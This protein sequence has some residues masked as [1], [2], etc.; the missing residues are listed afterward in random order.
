M[1]ERNNEQ[2]EKKQQKHTFYAVVSLTKQYYIEE[3]FHNT[4][5]ADGVPKNHIVWLTVSLSYRQ[6]HSPERL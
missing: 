6:H 5:I 2:H 3:H 1:N 4:Y